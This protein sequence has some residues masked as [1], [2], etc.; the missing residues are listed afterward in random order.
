MVSRVLKN[1]EKHHIITIRGDHGDSSF[2]LVGPPKR[3]YL[4]VHPADGDVYTSLSGPKSLR[5]LALAI[6]GQDK[7]R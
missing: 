7:R 5:A 6:L 2:V 4:S 3:Q 1:E